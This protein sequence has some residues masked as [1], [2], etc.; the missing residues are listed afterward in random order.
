MLGG[1]V[2][3]FIR[4]LVNIEAIVEVTRPYQEMRQYPLLAVV[5]VQPLFLVVAH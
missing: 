1:L 5:A 3:L 2:V 4:L